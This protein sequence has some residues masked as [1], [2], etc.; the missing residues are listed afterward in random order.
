MQGARA[1]PDAAGGCRERAVEEGEEGGDHAHPPPDR[2]KTPGRRHLCPGL[3]PQEGRGRGGA[4]ARGGQRLRRHLAQ[5]GRRGD[6]GVQEKGAVTR[7][8]TH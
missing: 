1:P 7:Y 2:G 4:E 5:L 3:H 6:N 8:P